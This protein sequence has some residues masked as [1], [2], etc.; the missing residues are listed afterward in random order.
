[1]KQ[2]RRRPQPKYETAID[3][4]LAHHLPTCAWHIYSGDRHCSCGRDEAILQLA[5]LRRR[6][7]PMELFALQAK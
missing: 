6:A 2:K 5:E 1:M 3:K 4:M 7:Q